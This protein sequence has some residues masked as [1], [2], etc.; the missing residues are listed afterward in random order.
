L[1]LLFRERRD[2]ENAFD[3]AGDWF[4][5]V[6]GARIDQ[7]EEAFDDSC[8]CAV[9]LE[10]YEGFPLSRGRYLR[11]FLRIIREVVNIESCRPSQY[12]R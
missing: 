9:A 7:S 5:V 8:C 1:N 2:P 11:W 6:L 4:D 12:V 3:N 10:V